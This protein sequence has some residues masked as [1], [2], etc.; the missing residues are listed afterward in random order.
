[1]SKQPSI[2][3]H[4]TV[5]SF[6]FPNRNKLKHFLHALFITEKKELESLSFVFCTDEYLLEFNKT[7]LKHHTLTDIITFELSAKGEPIM[8][9]VYISTERVK[10]NTTIH[11]TTFLKEL[12]RVIFHGALH[13]CGYK[14]KTPEQQKLM[15]KMEEHYLND[16]FVPRGTI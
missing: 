6:Y 4:Y 3:F 11:K 5:A 2:S 7:Y 9:D 12:H 8:G 13:L 15:R 1:M 10:E 16:Y 14:D